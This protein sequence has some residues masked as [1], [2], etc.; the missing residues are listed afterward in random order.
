MKRFGRRSVRTASARAALVRA[1][2]V[3]AASVLGACGAVALLAP[4]RFDPRNIAQYLGITARRHQPPLVAQTQAA[5]KILA[6]AK[7]QIGTRYDAS[8]RVIAYP[9]GDV[10]PAKGACTDVVI[11]ALRAAGY[12]LQKRVHDDMTARWNAYP[13]TWGLEAPNANIDHRRVPNQ[14]VYFA[15]YGR[16][17]PRSTSGADL[18]TWQVG[19]IIHWNT[20]EAGNTRLHT[21]IV[22]DTRDWRG[23]PYVIHNGSICIEDD[24]LDRWPIIG[25]FRFPA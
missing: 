11:R 23:L 5:A 18:K 21:G 10:D 16:Q 25:H 4:A 19:D 17:L 13:K 9:M 3:C 14:M 1:G 6:G 20:G 2:C 15:K 22:S 12:D 8:Y 24:A 7:A